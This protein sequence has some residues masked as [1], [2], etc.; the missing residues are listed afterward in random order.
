MI[1]KDFFSR[2]SKSD[3]FETPYSMTEQLL[4]NEKFDYNKEVGD[5]ACGN[6]AI[7]K[8][9]RHKFGGGV[10]HSDISMGHD[11]LN[12]KTTKNIEYLIMNPP[13]SLWDDFIKKAKTIATEKFAFLGRIEFLTGLKRFNENLYYDREY[14][15]TKIYL[16][17]RKVNLSC[18]DE[19]PALRE[20]GKYPAGMYHY[21]WF[22]FEKESYLDSQF[23]QTPSEPRIKRINNN[24]YIL[25]KS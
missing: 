23:L 7:V 3:F 17:V 22:V 1:G 25:R 14:P 9:L 20:D 4:E 18:S 15:L 6:Y 13:F 19:Y 21:A 8:I 5:F 24:P 16:F 10:W 12:F 2:E 11:F